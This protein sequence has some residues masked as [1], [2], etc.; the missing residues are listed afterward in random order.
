MHN[1]NNVYINCFFIIIIHFPQ[2][3]NNND[4]LKNYT[5]NGKENYEYPQNTTD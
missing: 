2:H 5:I 3:H 4:Q 1:C